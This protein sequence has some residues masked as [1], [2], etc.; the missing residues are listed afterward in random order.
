MS[1]DKKKKKFL[2]GM[3]HLKNE[4][5][6]PTSQTVQPQTNNSS[7]DETLH[8]PLKKELVSILLIMSILFLLLIGL[9]VYDKSGDGLST[10]AKKIVSIVIKE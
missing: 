3:E 5:I 6:A 4:Y 8:H 10:F 7:P 2:Q 9:M 1:K